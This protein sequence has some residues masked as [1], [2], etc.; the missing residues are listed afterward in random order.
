MGDRTFGDP[1]DDAPPAPEAAA[2]SALSSASGTD[3]S[4]A[5]R[6]RARGAD[7][8]PSAIMRLRERVLSRFASE[9]APLRDV[10]AESVK[11]APKA[12]RQALRADSQIL[13]YRG[14]KN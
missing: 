3:T 10:E 7:A 5:G 9:P 1:S 2:D 4:K 8:V 13:D 11:V 6:V 12:E 14:H